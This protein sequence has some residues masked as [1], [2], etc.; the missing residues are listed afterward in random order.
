LINAISIEK[1]L[2]SSG[3]LF[4]HYLSPMRYCIG[5]ILLIMTV[6]SCKT[7][8]PLTQK[9]IVNE[10]SPLYRQPPL[11]AFLIELHNGQYP[12]ER[13]LDLTPLKF[14]VY[15]QFAASHPLPIVAQ[16]IREYQDALI[17]ITPSWT[18]DY[19]ILQN[20][21]I[22]GV[23]SD[24]Y[25][26]LAQQK[27]SLTFPWL[28][29]KFSTTPPSSDF[30]QFWIQTL[31][32]SVMNVQQSD[33]F[34]GILLQNRSDSLQWLE[35][36]YAMI[37]NGYCTPLLIQ[38]L[39]R[40]AS[41]AHQLPIHR[42]WKPMSR[43]P[44]KSLIDSPLAAIAIKEWKQHTSHHDESNP[45]YLIQTLAKFNQTSTLQCLIE[46]ALNKK[47]AENI[48]IDCLLGLQKNDAFD[49][50]LLLPLLQ[51]ESSAIITLAIAIIAPK[52]PYQHQNIFIEQHA[53][54]TIS[55]AA[56]KWSE[57][58]WRIQNGDDSTGT[59]AWLEFLN[60]VSPYQRML[61]FQALQHAPSLKVN[62]VQHLLHHAATATDLYYGTEC[63]LNDAGR[64]EGNFLSEIAGPL[65]NTGDIGV[66]ALLADGIAHYPMS[67]ME[68]T[69]WT[70]RMQER[71]KSLVLPKE[72]ET[73]N[74]LIKAINLLSNQKLP[75]YTPAP[76]CD[77]SI[78]DVQGIQKMRTYQIT[79][80]S[81]VGDQKFLFYVH[82]E[83]NP[84]T[85][86]HFR[87]LVNIGFYNN[88]Y[89]HRW[90]PNF[91]IQGGCPRGDGMGSLNE[92]ISSEFNPYP[93]ITGTIGWA[94][95][96]PHTESCQIFFM[97]DD[98]PHL[99]GRYTNM[100]FTMDVDKLS[101]LRLGDQILKIEEVK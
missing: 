32:E 16:Q 57:Y 51:N 79:T 21:A 89:F 69:G 6:L 43:I 78:E 46:G 83:S 1:P 65:W 93:F 62:I 70:L 88:K 87:S 9:R 67:D 64:W 12:I 81:D 14:H 82:E 97:L 36:A 40:W 50:H 25:W 23:Q 60:V 47:N 85:A 3:F 75:T 2:P 66:Q 101:H 77:L 72:V 76:H 92:V 29:Q 5:F 42:L 53:D 59:K 18:E 13:I 58:A 26:A 74:E 17:P 48:R 80:T 100:G 19:F 4:Y 28:L 39:T 30:N 94:S 71:L 63:V 33:Q 84:I 61:A 49:A 98:A 22:R 68:K 38:S 34:C 31:G 99:D 55:S 20:Q 54:I 86:L 45:K 90:A 73:Y 52:I 27:D 10:I 95:A 15:C 41:G 56:I 11:A 44:K 7:S 24:I 96:G 35:G 37:K 8:H 91:V